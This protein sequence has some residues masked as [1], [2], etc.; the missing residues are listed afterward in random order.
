MCDYVLPHFNRHLMLCFF[1][2]NYYLLFISYSFKTMDMMSHKKQM[3]AIFLYKFK[4]GH[5]AV[6]TTQNNNNKAFGPGTANEHMVQWWFRK[7]LQSR[8][9]P[10]RWGT[11]WPAVES[12]Q[13]LT[14]RIIK[15]DPLT[16]TFEVAQELNVNHS[17]V[18]WHLK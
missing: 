3:W 8:W 13:W 17:V 2:M 16:T 5:R 9:E 18:L 7:D 12:W 15:A 10:W 6:E 14:E 11:Q 1:L 4:M